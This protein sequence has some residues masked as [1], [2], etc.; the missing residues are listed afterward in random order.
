MTRVRFP[1]GRGRKGFFALLYRVQTGSEN[2]SASYPMGTGG[3]LPGDTMA[4]A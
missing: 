1:A 2:H 4:R 3:P